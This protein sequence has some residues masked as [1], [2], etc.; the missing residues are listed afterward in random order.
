M[1]PGNP[2]A[3]PDQIWIADW[4]GRADASSTYIR[5]D[6]WIGRRIHQ[7]QGG[8]QETWGGVKINIDRDYLDLS[9]NAETTTPATANRGDE[10]CT[11]SSISQRSYRYADR[12]T[13]KRLALPLQCLLR[14][15]GL[16]TRSVTGRWNKA[17]THA[18]KAWQAKVHHKVHKGF[19]RSDWTSLLAAGNSRTVL[20]AKMSNDDVIRV[21]R[22]LNAATAA[23]LTVTGRYNKP[24][25]KAV[26]TY[27]RRVGIQATRVV[28]TKTWRALRKG[29]R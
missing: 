16:Y 17:T 2:I 6:G 13:H 3:L 19:S 20:T 12:H 27:Q 26:G 7:Y 25:R 4:N 24:T 9:G 23:K 11:S 15:Q 5:G 1:T 10:L 28:A 8:H 18:A 14:Q 29:R 21:Q 22:A